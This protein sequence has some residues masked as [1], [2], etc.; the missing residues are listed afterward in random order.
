MPGA[1][2][3]EQLRELSV[4]LGSGGAASAIAKTTI[5]PF[6]RTK[7]LLQT[8]SLVEGMGGH[9][10]YR[11][12]VDA[13]ARIPR[14]QGVAAFWRGNLTNI[15]RVVPTYALRFMFF[16]Q[17]RKLTSIG[18]DSSKPLPLSRQMAAGALS[19]S[20]TMLC[21]FPLDLL[22]T[23][24]SAEVTAAGAPRVYRGMYSSARRIVQAQG[25]SGLYQGIGISLFE[26]AP[27]LAI[28]FGGYE[29]LKERLP[30]PAGSDV[31]GGA[32][33][34]TVLGLWSKLGCGWLAGLS[35]SL[36]CY[37]ADTVKR[38][39]M[40]SGSA[41]TVTAASN[42]TTAPRV[43]ESVGACVARMYR[44]GGMQIFYRG[45]LIN[46]VNSGPAAAIT[47]VVNDL[48]RELLKL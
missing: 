15:S 41:A 31:E 16:D 3:S 14:E 45:C 44:A 32:G 19:G 38:Q 22:R 7:I 47:F 25:V 28:S 37:P 6:E 42:S 18:H 35:A 26:I 34:M 48:L 29:Y 27:Y 21:T 8:S 1:A 11:G 10:P 40:L 9:R 24:M 20:V 30:R 2:L 5:A 36:T 43:A 13:L 33:R 46:A 23:R 39:M 4:Q 12:V 17:F